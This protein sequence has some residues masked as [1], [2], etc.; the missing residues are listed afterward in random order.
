[1]HAN[2]AGVGVKGAVMDKCADGVVELESSWREIWA[3]RAIVIAP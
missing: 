3:K 1:L 2:E